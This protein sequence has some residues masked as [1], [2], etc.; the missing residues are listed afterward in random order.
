M[1]WTE[2]SMVFDI[3]A[4]WRQH[5]DHLIDD[6]HQESI[7]VIIHKLELDEYFKE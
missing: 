5:L 1:R 7:D 2:G 3:L 4:A 6:L